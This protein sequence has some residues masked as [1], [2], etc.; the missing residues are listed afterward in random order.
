MVG[1]LA[2]A[3][4]AE[5]AQPRGGAEPR[6]A[7]AGEGA[8]PMAVSGGMPDRLVERPAG[9][10]VHVASRF[11]RLRVSRHAYNDEE[12]ADRFVAAPA[13]ATHRHNSGA[14]KP[15]ADPAC[16]VHN[17]F[18]R[19]RKKPS[20]KRNPTGSLAD[21]VVMALRPPHGRGTIQVIPMKHAGI[22][23]VLSMQEENPQDRVA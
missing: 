5:A 3:Q 17:A 16:A 13:S 6:A 19:E 21:R 10:G 14:R 15:P 2:T 12:D 4:L 20:R 18:R 11:G 8:I 1:D 22:E 9:E 23:Q 7:G